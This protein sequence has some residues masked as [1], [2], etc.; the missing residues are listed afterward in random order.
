[1]HAP[2]LKSIFAIYA[3]A[4][5]GWNTKICHI[6]R[7]NEP[8]VIKFYD[9]HEN[10]FSCGISHVI[11]TTALK[12]HARN[13]GANGKES[14][15]TQYWFD[16]RWFSFICNIYSVGSQISIEITYNIKFNDTAYGLQEILFS[17]A[18]KPPRLFYF[19]LTYIIFLRNGWAGAS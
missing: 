2:P 12:R 4:Q 1:M 17:P 14:L 19:D 15:R 13:N 16:K 5:P 18:K 7:G 3:D 8:I 11:T 10:V 9:F 6:P